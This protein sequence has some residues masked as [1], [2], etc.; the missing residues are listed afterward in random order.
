MDLMKAS[1]IRTRGVTPDPSIPEPAPTEVPLDATAHASPQAAAGTSQQVQQQSGYHY[2]SE[3]SSS[4]ATSSKPDGTTRLAAYIFPQTV[5]QQRSLSVQ[6]LQQL[7]PAVSGA[8]L[9]LPLRAHGSQPAKPASVFPSAAP[10]APADP[11]KAALGQAGFDML[12][13]KP[14]VSAVIGSVPISP[15]VAQALKEET[16]PLPQ[17]Q[18]SMAE[19]AEPTAA[20]AAQQPTAAEPAAAA[21]APAGQDVTGAAAVAAVQAA[22]PVSDK[23]TVSASAAL[24]PPAARVLRERAV[25]STSIG[26]A[27][28]FAG[29]CQACGHT[30]AAPHSATAHKHGYKFMEACKQPAGHAA[31]VHC[32][33]SSRTTGSGRRAPMLSV[34]TAAS[35]CCQATHTYLPSALHPPHKPPASCPSPPTGMGA[36]LLLGSLS[37]SLTRAISPPKASS[38]ESKTGVYDAFITEANAERLANALC[39]MRGA[40]LK[41][42]QMLSIQDENV[43]P[44]QVGAAVGWWWGC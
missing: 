37:D 18:G 38:S 41:L 32:D 3:A 19:A 25:P 28:G 12:P 5:Q 29:G 10:A 43:L 27:L 11:L 31:H 2:L 30:G 34:A 42:G 8:T 20:G 40:A 23:A 21:A 4:G 6:Q 36:S 44:P 26:R 39:R 7:N 9:S 14:A 1:A 15:T 22:Q 35:C 17:V 16:H 13:M 24:Q 33:T